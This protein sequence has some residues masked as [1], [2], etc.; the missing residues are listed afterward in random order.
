[1]RKKCHFRFRKKATTRKRGSG[2]GVQQNRMKSQTPRISSCRV[3][4]GTSP[5]EVLKT[6]NERKAISGHFAM[7]LK[8]QFSLNYAYLQMFQRRSFPPPRPPPPLI[9]SMLLNVFEVG[10]ASS[11]GCAYRLASKRSLVRSSCPAHRGDLVVKKILR[12]FSPFRWFKKSSCR[13]LA[14]EYA[15]STGKLP[16]RLAQEVWIG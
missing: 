15:L 7:R 9:Y 10:R 5:G 8:S 12:P 11:V 3:V 13:L 4:R 2:W 6:K 14:K 16:R 1:M